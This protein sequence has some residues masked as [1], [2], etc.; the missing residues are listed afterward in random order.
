L[1]LSVLHDLEI[2]MESRDLNAIE[3][4]SWNL[5]KKLLDD[6]YL[7]EESYL[8][9]RSR[10]K[11]LEEGDLNTSYFHKVATARKKRNLILSMEIEGQVTTSLSDIQK[12]IFHFYKSLFGSKG[13]KVAKL[14]NQFWKDKYLLSDL[15][16]QI[17]SK[18]FTEE[19]L[20]IAVF[21]SEA[22]GAPGQDGFSFLFYQHF[23]EL[24]KPDLLVLLQKFYSNSLEE[25]RLNHAMVCL[26]P[27]EQEAKI[28]QKYRPISLVDCCFKILSKV[29]TNRLAPFMHSLVDQSQSTFIKGRYILDNVLA[30]NEI[31]HATKQAKHSGVVLKV[32]FEKAYDRVNWDFI[33]EILLSRGFGL[34]WTNWIMKLLQGAQTCVNINGS[35]TQYFFCKQRL[36]QMDPLSLSCLI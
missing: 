14:D 22:F 13:N 1:A 32:D 2:I 33:R 19:E 36:R 28:I 16:R 35:P 34:T 4:A 26:V 5:H 24:V 17:L 8:K 29:L 15:D 12:H 30:A 25:A 21:G 27:K 31:I 11:W 10:N 20:K 18:P 23:F 7:E 6:Y 9:Q 3:L